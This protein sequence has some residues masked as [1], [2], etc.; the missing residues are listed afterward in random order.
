MNSPVPEKIPMRFCYDWN[1]LISAV[2]KLKNDKPTK[3][4]EK[5]N[6]DIDFA[7]VNVNASL[8]FQTIVNIIEE[9]ENSTGNNR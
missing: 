2:R 3:Y 8:L 5:Y 9:Y 7:L 4:W 1:R 6:R